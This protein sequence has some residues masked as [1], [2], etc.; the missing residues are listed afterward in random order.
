M[1]S[2]TIDSHGDHRIA[3]SFMIAGLQCGMIVNDVDC[4]NTSFPN[5]FDL[6]QK[7]TKIEIK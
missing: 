4:V 1:N 7:I 3:M 6:L 2:A 5:F